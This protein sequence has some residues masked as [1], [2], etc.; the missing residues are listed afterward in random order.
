[1]SDKKRRTKK[2]K[3]IAL[4]QAIILLLAAF[5]AFYVLVLSKTPVLQFMGRFLSSAEG[6]HSIKSRRVDSQKPYPLT[7]KQSYKKELAG[8]DSI[9]LLIIGTDVESGNYDTLMIVSLDE[10]NNTVK[11]IN[12]PRDIYIAYSD[13]VLSRLK[14]AFPKYDA[15]KGIYKINAAHTIGK[16]IDYLKGAGRFGSSEYDFTADLIVEVFGLYIDD[17]VFLK[18]S[19]FKRVVDYFGGV[20]IEVPYRMKY[21]DPLQNLKIDLK[22]GF[23]HLNGTQ[24]EGFVR[25]RQGVNEKGKA[26]SIGDIERKQNQITFMKAFIEQHLNLG[27][28]GKIITIVSDLQEYLVSSVDNAT[29]TAEYGKIAEKLYRSKFTLTS[30]EIACDNKK[31]KDVYYLILTDPEKKKDKE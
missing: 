23:Q 2:W 28:I 4:I 8:K 20:D 13:E 11:I 3:T 5:V 15:A 14:K 25:F 9:N 30:E 10:K 12:I 18:P 22:K 16:K 27:N 6:G 17:F 7:D 29:E 24:A 19:S 21:T 26:V 31:I 1:M